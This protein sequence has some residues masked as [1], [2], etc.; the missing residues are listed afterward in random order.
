M[1]LSGGSKMSLQNE[2]HDLCKMNVDLASLKANRRYQSVKWNTFISLIITCRFTVFRE[3]TEKGR[4]VVGFYDPVAEADGL[5][6]KQA[7][8]A[9]I[10]ANELKAILYRIA[11]NYQE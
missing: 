11:E 1:T 9:Q 10:A 4:I 3:S 7:Q 5:N 2:F 8:A 6:L